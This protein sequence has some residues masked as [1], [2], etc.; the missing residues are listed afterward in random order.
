MTRTTFNSYQH[1]QI[2]GKIAKEPEMRYTPAGKEVTSISI[3]VEE[4]WLNSSGERVK[5]TTWYRVTFWE[6]SAIFVNTWS[7]KGTAVLVT[8]KLVVDPITGGPKTYQKT[9][10]TT[11]TS[12]E[13]QPDT[14][15]LLAGAKTK[16]EAGGNQPAEQAHQVTE[17]ATESLPVEDDIP[18]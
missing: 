9:D 17:Q 16:E 8:G 13:I 10:G 6:K 15:V 12:F 18:F 4:S 7:K 14:I 2:A 5:V 3:P 1:V 11:G